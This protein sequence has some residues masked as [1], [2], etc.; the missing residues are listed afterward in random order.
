MLTVS[1]TE[2]SS[3]PSSYTCTHVCVCALALPG[4]SADWP[5]LHGCLQASRSNPNLRF[6]NDSACTSQQ[7]PVRM[8]R[9]WGR[10]PAVSEISLCTNKLGKV[11]R[12][13]DTG[14]PSTQSWNRCQSSFCNPGEASPTRDRTGPFSTVKILCH[15]DRM[16][17]LE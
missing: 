13:T 2:A 14:D 12:C 5:A 4:L 16:K 8:S 17:Y 15:I 10:C 11:L 1:V 9:H 7:Q 6:E 3:P